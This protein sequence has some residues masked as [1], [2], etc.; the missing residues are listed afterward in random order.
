M[1]ATWL[2]YILVQSFQPCVNQSGGTFVESV[3]AGTNITAYTG[4]N[5]KNDSASIMRTCRKVE[6]DSGLSF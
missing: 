3:Y 6:G 4:P 2:P 1:I 5:L